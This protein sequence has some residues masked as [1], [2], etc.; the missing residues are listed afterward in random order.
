MRKLVQDSNINIRKERLINRSIS[1]RGTNIHKGVKKTKICMPYKPNKCPF[2]SL[3][4]PHG[5]RPQFYSSKPITMG[6]SKH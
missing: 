5:T 1:K 4:F 2:L 6:L 3:F